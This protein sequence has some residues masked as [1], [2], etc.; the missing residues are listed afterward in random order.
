[1]GRFV[2][3][4]IVFIFLVGITLHYKFDIPY[5]LSWIGELPG[6][7]IIKKG[8][9]FFYFPVTTAAILSLVLTI[10]LHCFSKKNK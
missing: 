8:N 6:D 9:F 10:I 2:F 3:W 5:F 1:M 7:M 4:F